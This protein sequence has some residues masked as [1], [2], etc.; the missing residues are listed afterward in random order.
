[1]RA[2]S[3]FEL[4]IGAGWRSVDGETYGP[5]RS[6]P[7]EGFD[8]GRVRD[9]VQIV[10]D[11]TSISGRADEDS[12][13][14]LVRDLLRAVDRLMRDEQPVRVSYYEGPWELALQRIGEEAY[15]TFYKGG[16]IPE[17]V[18][19]DRP[20]TFR[21]LAEGVLASGCDLVSQA[22]ALDEF[23]ET[24]PLIEEIRD[25]DDRIAEALDQGIPALAATAP[26][27]VSVV[28][29]RWRRSRNEDGFSMGFRFEATAT[30]VLMPGKPAGSDINSLL[31]S[32]RHAVHFRGKRLVL[33]QGFLF[34]QTE[35]LLAS[36]RELLAAWEEGRPMT[37]RM[38]SDGLIVGVR[39]RRDDGLV[40]SLANGVR[41]DSLLVLNDLTP[42]A[43]AE[44][45]L[46]VARELRRTIVKTNPAQRRNMRP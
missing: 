43:Y 19:K 37:A 29:T 23:A 31:F 22:V 4:V 9:V 1:M 41:E 45:V 5:I 3:T 25:L 2:S 38:I 40:I 10:I 46:A 30:D 44:A 28:S 16:H 13:F 32:G 15:I 39:L 21:A 20:V 42:W 17:V 8:F 24:D 33:G 6:R 27:T 35:R 14:Y 26:E 34:L 7:R 11:G 18:V 12:I 36:V